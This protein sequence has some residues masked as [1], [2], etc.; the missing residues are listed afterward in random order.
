MIRKKVVRKA[1]AMRGELYRSLVLEAAEQEFAAHGFADARVQR[2]ADSVGLSVGTLYNLFESKEG[3]YEELHKK[4]ATALMEQLVASLNTDAPVQ[5]RLANTVRTLTAFA[6]EHP[7]YLR[8]VFQRG[9][10]WSNQSSHSPVLEQRFF[11]RGVELASAL[12]QLA[13]SRGE[14]VEDEPRRIVLTLMAVLQA[15]MASWLDSGLN[16]DADAVSARIISLFSR[17]Y[18]I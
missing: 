11:Q 10:A 6:A 13:I 15:Q 18:A 16:E 3:L 7:D 9:N 17:M 4:R 12:C 14:M 2:V 5:E 1:H 8:M